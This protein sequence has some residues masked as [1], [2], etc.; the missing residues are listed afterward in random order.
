MRR[1]L[2]VAAYMAGKPDGLV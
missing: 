2:Q 1:A